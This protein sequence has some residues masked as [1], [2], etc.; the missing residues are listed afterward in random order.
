MQDEEKLYQEIE[1]LQEKLTG[2]EEYIHRMEQSRLIQTQEDEKIRYEKIVADKKIERLALELLLNER[3]P[4]DFSGFQLR[5]L[6][7]RAYRYKQNS[8]FTSARDQWHQI[9]IQYPDHAEAESAINE[10]KELEELKIRKGE[11]RTAL[12]RR[13]SEIKNIYKAVVQ[14]LN[15]LGDSGED[16]A[17]LESIH[18]YINNEIDAEDFIEEWEIHGDQHQTTAQPSIDYQKLA[19]RITKGEIIVFLGSG[20]HQEYNK[21]APNERTFAAHLAEDIPFNDHNKRLPAV[22][23]F[24]ECRTDLGRAALLEKLQEKLPSNGEAESIKLYH[25]LAS[26][27]RPLILITSAYDNLLEQAFI[28][29]NKPFVEILSITKPD[30]QCPVGDVVLRYSDIESNPEDPLSYS[31]E[32]LSSL[33]LL[34]KGY[35]LIYKI[36]GS[37]DIGDPRVFN[38]NSP[39]N[40]ALTLMESDYFNFARYADRIIPSYI[41]SQFRTKDFMFVGFRPR[42]WEDRLLVNA[43]FEQRYSQNRKRILIGSSA[44]EM[45]KA[46]WESR[47]VRGDGI[48]IHQLDEHLRTQQAGALA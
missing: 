1:K 26:T 21:L 5:V 17:F 39:R 27:E 33:N 23:E 11:L 41:S 10:L 18:M 29:H 31:K 34:A 35:S 6:T 42:F 8:D 9:Q 4:D 37:C 40:D 3:R 48:S 38:H 2:L 45:E 24:Y 43:I 46:Y 15:N 32:A 12:V 30:G 20:V 22:A 7:N 14:A 28:L 25:S 16:R 47:Q 36:R 44:S 13:K 19:H